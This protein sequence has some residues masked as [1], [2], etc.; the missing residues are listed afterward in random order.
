MATSAVFFHGVR[1]GCRRRA[2]NQRIAFD[3]N[4]REYGIRFHFDGFRFD[5]IILNV[6]AAGNDDRDELHAGRIIVD[7]LQLQLAG[8]EI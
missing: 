7:V 2:D 8:P 4:G 5:G 1:C 6:I 3:R